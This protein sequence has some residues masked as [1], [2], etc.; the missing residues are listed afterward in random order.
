MSYRYKKIHTSLFCEGVYI[1][2]WVH[3]GLLRKPHNCSHINN[4][5]KKLE[6]LLKDKKFTY[7][8]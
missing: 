4:D 3:V 8:P 2:I 5:V 6:N 1:S 7:I